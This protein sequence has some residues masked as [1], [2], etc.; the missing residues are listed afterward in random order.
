MN[1]TISEKFR[2][3]DRLVWR[4]NKKIKKAPT[5]TLPDGAINSASQIFNLC[6]FISINF[7]DVVKFAVSILYT[8]TPL[9]NP[10]ALKLT[11][12]LPAF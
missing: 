5:S 12:Y 11:S 10:A 3:E 6:Y 8:Y 2:I 9:D 4:L 1:L 7:F